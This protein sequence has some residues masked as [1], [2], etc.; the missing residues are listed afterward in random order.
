MRRPSLHIHTTHT[1]DAA[2]LKLKR[3]NRWLIMGSIVLTGVLADVAASA[4]PG[5][6]KTT[7]KGATGTH[8]HTKKS[9]PVGVLAPPAKAPESAPNSS[10]GEGSADPPSEGSAGEGSSAG[11]S[12]QSS[13]APSPETSTAPESSSEAQ[14]EAQSEEPSAES[15]GPVVSGGS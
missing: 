14:S 4:F 11:E 15:S 10:S 6:T 5:K 2:L 1:R 8:R 12:P 9:D 13:E 3:V 7:A